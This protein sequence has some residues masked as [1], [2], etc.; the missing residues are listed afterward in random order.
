MGTTDDEPILLDRKAAAAV[1]SISPRMLDYAIAQG[2]LKVRR[3]GKRVLVPRTEI[4]RFARRDHPRLS[5]TRKDGHA[6]TS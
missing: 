5:P 3:I 4:E 2:R 6:A 1:L